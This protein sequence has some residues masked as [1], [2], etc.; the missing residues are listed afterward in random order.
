MFDDDV[1]LWMLVSFLQQYL[2]VIKAW[3]TWAAFQ[4]LLHELKVVAQKHRSTI[5]QVA[6]R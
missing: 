2:A 3:G 5:A 1:V 4:E 6:M